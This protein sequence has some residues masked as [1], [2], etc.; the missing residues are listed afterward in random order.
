MLAE[1]NQAARD[2]IVELETTLEES[3]R[4]STELGVRLSRSEEL[5]R[6]LSAE[7]TRLGTILDRG[8][9]STSAI[10]DESEA[11]EGSI[12][13]ALDIVRELKNGD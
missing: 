5:V 4:L 9:T 3:E 7:N 1:Q 12:D 8:V 13:R 11:I 6:G 10:K 2:R